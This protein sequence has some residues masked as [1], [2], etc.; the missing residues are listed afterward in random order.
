MPQGS[1]SIIIPN[2][3]V[4]LR[5]LG[6][7]FR[8][9][10]TFHGKVGYKEKAIQSGQMGGIIEAVII[11][12]GS[13][14]AATTLIRQF[15]TWLRRK[16]E[17]YTAHLTMKDGHGREVTLDVNGLTDPEAITQKAFEFFSSDNYSNE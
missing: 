2:E 9:D 6:E 14:G 1:I 4:G 7:W 11:A 10:D 12:V 17:R 13:G 3:S 8:A 15:F 5:E 16:G